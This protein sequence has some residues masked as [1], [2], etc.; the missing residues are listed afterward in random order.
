[1]KFGFFYLANANGHRWN[2]YI[3]HVISQDL[4]LFL[5]FKAKVRKLIAK[6]PPFVAYKCYI[7]YCTP[8]IVMAVPLSSQIQ[9]SRIFF[10]FKGDNDTFRTFIT[11]ISNI[12]KELLTCKCPLHYT[13]KSTTNLR[14]IKF[15]DTYCQDCV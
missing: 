6:L 1:M 7:V 15:N 14:R 10:W 13:F 5:A 4:F 8:I 9:N 3:G 11:I 2:K 12:P